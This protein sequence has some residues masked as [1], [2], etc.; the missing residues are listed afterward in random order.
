[1]IALDHVWFLAIALTIDAAFGDPQFIWSRLPHPVAAIGG[2]IGILDSALN[3]AS[4]TPRRRQVAGAVAI[5]VIVALAAAIGA[6][7]EAL[8]ASFAGGWAGIAIAAAILLAGRSLYDHVAAVAAA[9]GD[10]GLGAGRAAVTRI[11]G[12]DAASLDEASVCRAA[13]ETLAENFSDALVAP[14][15][16][17]MVLGLPGIAAYKA[18]NTADSM[19]GH[20]SARHADFGWAA[21]RLDDLLNLPAGRLSGVLIALAAPFGGGKSAIAF[22]TMSADA[23]RHA[24]PNAGW[25][26]AA[27]AGALG[28][29]LGGPKS[30]GGELVDDAWL[31][32]SGRVEA[33]PGDIARALALYLA[34]SAMVWGAAAIAG[35]AVLLL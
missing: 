33:K 14:A 17:F 30:Y 18:I 2:L 19:I 7:L 3:T 31:N 34:A 23:R 21:A 12:R 16:W 11:V 35:L 13:I 22:R 8:F 27:M 10:G 28:L 15:L 6:A 5:A 20:R 25:P 4:A 32:P 1:L 29:A 26:E 9:L 24:S